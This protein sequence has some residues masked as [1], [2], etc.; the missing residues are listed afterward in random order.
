MSIQTNL[1]EAS[2]CLHKAREEALIPTGSKLWNAV[3]VLL[4]DCRQALALALADPGKAW[5][6]ETHAAWENWRATPW[7]NSRTICFTASSAAGDLEKRVKGLE[8][9][10]GGD[11]HLFAPRNKLRKEQADLKTKRKGVSER[12]RA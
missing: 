8:D 3:N 1:K 4:I 6:E 12:T 5:M 9:G 2:R 10:R 11:T 7:D